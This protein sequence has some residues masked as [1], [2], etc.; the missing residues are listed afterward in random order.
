MTQP[1]K[2]FASAGKAQPINTAIPAPVKEEKQDDKEKDTGSAGA[3]GDDDK[4]GK[5]NGTEEADAGKEKGA[6]EAADKDKEK[7]EKDGVKDGEI[8]EAVLIADFN[9]RFGKDV[10]TIAE[11]NAI[12]NPPKEL[13]D[14]EKEEKE[15]AVDKRMADFFVKNGGKL[16]E[17]VALKQV[18]SSDLT[19]I[20][21]NVLQ[22][23][24]KTQGFDDAQIAHIIKERYYQIEDADI[25][26]IED[27]T[28]K[29]L[30]KKK[31]EYGQKALEGRGSQIK[32]RAA[33]TINNLRQ[34][35]EDEEAETLTEGQFS[36]N[37]DEHLKKVPRKLTFEL[38]QSNDETLA[39]VD[40]DVTEDDIAKVADVLK[41]PAKRKQ[42]LYNEDGVTLNIS[43]VSNLMLRNNI[44]ER[45]LKVALLEGQSRQV[46]VFKDAFGGKDPRDIG[47][48]GSKGGG[49]NGNAKDGKFKKPASFGKPQPM[50]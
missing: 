5:E 38:G 32:Q 12:I 16:E 43:S 35:V 21:I 48:G 10:K 44:L 2:K 15:R 1:N 49:N 36:S 7:E 22:T 14:A 28:E 45:A 20:S 9:K 39:P 33:D 46:E 27:E 40:V 26:V 19:Q 37:V 25:D 18:A 31:K 3:G 23:E 34:A 13:T 30:L 29:S 6:E 4:G 41:D 8:P 42:F 24:L 50:N 17:Y 47:V 11:M